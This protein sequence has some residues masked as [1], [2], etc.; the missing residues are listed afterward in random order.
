MSFRDA[1]QA[2]DLII[3]ADD[4]GIASVMIEY[5][6]L[7]SVDVMPRQQMISMVNT[8][9]LSEFVGFSVLRAAGLAAVAKIPQIRKLAISQGLAPSSNLPFAMRG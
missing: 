9:L 6:K 1:A 5:N 3:G 2:A 4:P 7:R 8:S